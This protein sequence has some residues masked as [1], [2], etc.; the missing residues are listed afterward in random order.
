MRGHL[1]GPL[2]TIARRTIVP[3][4]PNC[5]EAMGQVEWRLHHSAEEWMS[6]VAAVER[7][8]HSRLVAFSC[9]SPSGEV[10][11]RS[12]EEPAWELALLT[13]N[14][15]H[16]RDDVPSQRPKPISGSKGLK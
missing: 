12:Q 8:I 11:A 7:N 15:M 3:L 4:I 13:Y 1:T 9:P 16:S 14:T 10:D 6:D 2:L 5:P